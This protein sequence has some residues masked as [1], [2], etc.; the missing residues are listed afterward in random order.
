[1]EYLNEMNWVGKML[2]LTGMVAWLV[3]SALM[4]L[5]GA[6]LYHWIIN[7]IG[8]TVALT[9]LVIKHPLTV[10]DGHSKI[11]AI[12]GLAWR[13]ADTGKLYMSFKREPV[14]FHYKNPFN[15]KIVRRSEEPEDDRTE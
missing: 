3:I 15:W 5:L 7:F 2:I 13:E 8:M 6:Y 14:D 9:V 10:L 12:V 1:M 11:C 4:V